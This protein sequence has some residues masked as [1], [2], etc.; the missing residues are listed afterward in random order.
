MRTHGPFNLVDEVEL[1]KVDVFCV[2][3]ERYQAEALERAVMME[4]QPGEASSAVH[5]ASA[6]DVV[7]TKLRA[8]SRAAARPNGEITMTDLFKDK[9]SDWDARPVPQQISEGV[10]AALLR[11][12]PLTSDLLVMDFGAGTGLIAARVAPLVNRMVA[13]D[14]SPAMLGQLAQKPELQG[15]V[16]IACEDITKQPLGRN[17]DLVVS[18][19]AMHHVED[20]AALMRALFQHLQPGGRIALADLDKEDGSFHPPD[21][22]GVFHAGFD[23]AQ[24]GALCTAAG[25]TDV[26]FT[27]ACEVS[28][29]GKRFPIFLLQALKPAAGSGPA[30]S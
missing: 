9:A 2:A 4:L 12:V 7:L 6:T 17:V 10:F 21:A 16:D 13:V 18:A 25:F 19:M 5:V 23:R 28:R 3:A 20:T 8:T 14:V 15:R 11:A 29:D 22:Q 26:A 27:T 24:L 30:A 1:A